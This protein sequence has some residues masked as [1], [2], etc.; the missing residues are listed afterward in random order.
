MELILFSH[1]VGYAAAAV[2]AGVA[3]VVVDWEWRGKAERQ[4]GW[5]TQ[6]NRAT[7]QDV[8]AMRAAIGDRVICRVNNTPPDRDDEC[9][10]AVDH[11]ACE[12]WLPMVRDVRE[13]EGC[14]RAIDGRARLGVMVETRQAMGLGRAL[15]QLPLAHA[16][17][18]LHDYHIDGGSAQLFDPIVDGT[19]D[20][21]RQEYSGALG[22]AGITRPCGGHPIPQRLLLAAMARL[23][24]SFGVARRGFLAD[25]PVAGLNAGIDEIHDELDRLVARP[26]MEIEG[27]HAAL[28]RLLGHR[29]DAL[30]I[31]V[32]ACAS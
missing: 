19:L 32:V 10:A 18:G 27:D 9:R 23:G 16:Y 20:R 30:S 24:C 11:G 21:F 15:A 25:I 6:I 28:A 7:P 22:V 3:H 8:Q 2:A 5:D 26:A 1:D 4:C 14:L 29:V 13:V 17:V 12:V 31:P